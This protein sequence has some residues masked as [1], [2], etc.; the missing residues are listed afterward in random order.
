MPQYILATLCDPTLSDFK[1][2]NEQNDIYLIGLMINFI[3]HQTEAIKSGDTPMNKIVHK[4]LD[5]DLDNRYKSILEIKND[6]KQVE[7]Q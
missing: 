2:Y 7:V 5:V 1:N 3:Y 4:C 6:I